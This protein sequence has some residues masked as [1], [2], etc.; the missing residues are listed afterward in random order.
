LALNVRIFFRIEF[1]TKQEEGEKT[2]LEFWIKQEERE[3]KS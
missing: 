3:K 2:I 1:K